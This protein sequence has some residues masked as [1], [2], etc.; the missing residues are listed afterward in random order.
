MYRP[1]YRFAILDVDGT[2]LDSMYLWRTTS[3][4]YLRNQGQQE[5]ADR[6]EPKLLYMSVYQAMEAVMPYCESAHIPMISREAI[7]EIQKENYQKTK[8]KAGAQEFLEL[9]QENG[10]RM[11]VITST[12]HFLVEEALENAGLSSYFE[13]I[14]TAED[15]SQG[16]G[17][18]AIFDEALRRFG[19]LPEETALIDDALYCLQT[20][21]DVGIRTVAVEDAI[22]C[23]DRKQIQ[24][25]ADEYYEK[26]PV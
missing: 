1:S 4:Q 14:L 24:E 11:C 18:R 17:S 13:F 15:F 8:K 7:W 26:F 22:N 21:K 5:L 10:V 12:E 20:A 23:F 2:L 6:L 19:A 9:L 16:K 25:L 3:V